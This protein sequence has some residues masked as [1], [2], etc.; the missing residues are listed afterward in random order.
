MAV[1]G[2]DVSHWQV[3]PSGGPIQWDDVRR[4]GKV[5]AFLKATDGMSPAPPWFEINRKAARA[6]DVA[7]GAYHFARFH[8]DPADQAAHFAATIGSTS[9]ELPPAL[10]LE[11]SGL[12]ENGEVGPSLSSSQIVEW[13]H[14]FLTHARQETGRHVTIYVPTS[15][16]HGP[17]GNTP[18]FA[19]RRLWIASWTSGA[20]PGPLP[21][22]WKTWTFW[23]YSDAGAVA[24]IKGNVDLD[25]FNGSAK[26]LAALTG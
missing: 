12:K 16:W 15:F 10:D 1:E 25:R 2:I 18:Q 3:G 8:E 21:G 5:F 24:G 14:A 11:D 17:V 26:D 19:E 7:V 23:Q 4:A 9:G 20:S 22:A 13:I 6:A